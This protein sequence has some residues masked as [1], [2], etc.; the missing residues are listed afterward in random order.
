MLIAINPPH[1]FLSLNDE[2]DNFCIGNLAAEKAG[3]GKPLGVGRGRGIA[4]GSLPK[5]SAPSGYTAVSPQYTCMAVV[6]E[7]TLESV[8]NLKLDRIVTASDPGTVLNPEGYATQVEGGAV[9]G[10]T[11]ALYGQITVRNGRVVEGNFDDYRMM[12]INEVPKVETHVTASGGFFGGIG[13]LP[14]GLMA[15]SVGNALYA[16]GGPRIRSLPFMNHDL[17]PRK[18]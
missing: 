11:S 17:S 12:R 6:A 1:V 18:T 4:I 13:E 14:V 5:G 2:K 16:A 7:V 10:L 9:F 3:W 8:G 15:P